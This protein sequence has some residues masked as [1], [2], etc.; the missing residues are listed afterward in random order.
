MCVRA[1]SGLQFSDTNRSHHTRCTATAAATQHT[2]RRECC[3]RNPETVAANVAS[4]FTSTSGLL[5]GT[6]GSHFVTRE[7]KSHRR[8]RSCVTQKLCD[9]LSRRRAQYQCRPRRAAL[10]ATLRAH[11]ARVDDFVGRTRGQ[12]VTIARVTPDGAVFSFLI[13][14]RPSLVYTASATYY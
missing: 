2:P 13:G 5:T 10:R 4:L 11:S 7:V 9:A 14:T 6:S 8:S 12:L 3:V 1:S